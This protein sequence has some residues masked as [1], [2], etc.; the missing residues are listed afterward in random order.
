MPS[1]GTVIKINH[2]NKKNL[3]LPFIFLSCVLLIAINCYTIRI[4]SDVRAYIYGESEYSKGQKDASLFLTAYI[5]L[6]DEHYWGEFNRAIAIPRGDKL[7]RTALV[8]GRPD[9]IIAN[10]FLAGN[11]HPED[12]PGLIWLFRKFQ[13]TFF[14]KD[15]I[16][17]WGEAD[18]LIDQLQALGNNMHTAMAIR[19]LTQAEKERSVRTINAVSVVLSKKQHAFS[20]VLGK[21]SRDIN[22]YLLIAN[23]TCILVILGSITFYVITVMDNMNRARYT[24]EQ[25]NTELGNA[26][27]ELDTFVYS[28]SHDLRSPITSIKGLVYIALR[29]PNPEVLR[30]YLIMIDDV[31]DKQ[32]AFIKE[33]ISF[34]KN[35]RSSVVI[36]EVSL[37]AVVDEVINNNRFIPLAQQMKITRQ[38]GMDTVH[39][40]DLRLKMILN[41]LV[42][43]A[44]KYSDE[45]KAERWLEVRTAQVGDKLQLE[46]EDN[47]VGIEKEYFE[48]IFHMFFVTCSDNRGTGL[49]LYI[50]KQNVDKLEGIIAVQ[51]KVGVGTKITITLPNCLSKV[52]V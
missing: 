37:A 2:M 26:S 49:G 43:N 21:T 1:I 39:C 20:E 38:I 8:S 3:L 40:D 32:D 47:G 12:V 14:M 52:A 34:F 50:L 51:S 5:D 35:K 23:I 24:L 45:R 10:G 18:E 29:E 16:R 17:L 33:I 42:S 28:L 9:S 30:D 46:V 41:N 44:I 36:K 7:A 13:H 27:K 11:N 6:Q 25:K 19:P 22:R 4:L 48:K 31:I 15:A